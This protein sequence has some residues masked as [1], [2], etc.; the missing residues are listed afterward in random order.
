MEVNTMAGYQIDYKGKKCVVTGGAS[1][2]GASVVDLLLK[3]GAEVCLLDIKEA[4]APVKL[5][6]PVNL[7]DPASI[8]AA[9]EK[10]PD[11]VDHVFHVAGL[12]GQRYGDKTFAD[13][14]VVKVNFIGAKYLLEKLYPKM[15]D[16][17]SV[18]T[19]ASIAGWNWRNRFAQYK[20]FV[21]LQGWDEQLA[22]L[23]PHE[24]DSEW[25]SA[26]VQKNRAYE[27]S[28][29]CLI[30]YTVIKSWELAARKIRINAEL[31]GG[32]LTPMHDD[33][34][35]ISGRDL[36]DGLPTAPNGYESTPEMQAGA[37]LLLN[38]N[39]AE[40]VS[41]QVL[42]VDFGLSNAFMYGVANIAPAGH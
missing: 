26:P 1:G 42:S 17:G 41:G 19:V 13:M 37:M 3:N 34:V 14:D 4:D 6:V 2:M 10:L 29:E 40:Y 33:F 30:I 28:K 18:V 8:D 15:N 20:D 25:Y 16:G 9:V 27:F 5:F 21:M 22:Y 11:G 38:S 31:P 24:G 12:P 39:L 32:T 35:K 36:A 7:A 23:A